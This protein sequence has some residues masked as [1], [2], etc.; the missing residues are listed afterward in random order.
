[1]ELNVLIS[2]ASRGLGFSIAD[3]LAHEGCRII[4]VARNAQ[5]LNYA[6]SK[7]PNK[8][9]HIPIEL[10]LTLSDSI[11]QL[12]NTLAQ[13]SIVPDIIIHNLGGKVDGD[14]H[15]LEIEVLRKSM[16]LNVEVAIN[17]N[18]AFMPLMKQ[19]GSGKI[20]HISSDAAITANAAPAYSIAKAALNAYIV[21]T[22]RKNIKDNIVIYGVMPGI[23]EH[24]D[25]A[26]SNKKIT[27]PEYY[28]NKSQNMPLGRF[29]SV[30]EVS[31]VISLLC[32][33]NSIAMS[34]S[35]ITLNGAA[36]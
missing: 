21:N 19:R 25:S 34:G 33:V 27:A 35:L 9:K 8:S 13:I 30:E 20:I 3:K 16:Q 5:R 28:R 36:L 26:W 32:S 12:V 24:P 22:A 15:P 7:L 2:G 14:D 17:I 18:N 29:L 31:D 1:M 11:E 10:D 4:L 6:V 23:F